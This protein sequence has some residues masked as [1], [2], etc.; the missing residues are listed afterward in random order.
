MALFLFS[1]LHNYTD[2]TR[3]KGIDAYIHTVAGYFNDDELAQSFLKEVR[4][5]HPRYIRDQLDMI[6][7][8][9]K[10]TKQQE[11]SWTQP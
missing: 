2:L 10:R 3:T 7:R 1:F 6:L 8:Q 4:S 9:I 11:I 5:R